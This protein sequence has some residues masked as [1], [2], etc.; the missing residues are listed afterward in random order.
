MYWERRKSIPE[1][2][3]VNTSLISTFLRLYTAEYHIER[4]AIYFKIT[5]AQAVSGK[6][7]EEEYESP[8]NNEGDNTHHDERDLS[9]LISVIQ[10]SIEDINRQP[11]RYGK[12]LNDLSIV[13]EGLQEQLTTSG[14][15]SANSLIKQKL[16]PR[17]MEHDVTNSLS[18]LD[19]AISESPSNFTSAV[20]AWRTPLS[21][22]WDDLDSAIEWHLRNVSLL[23]RQLGSSERIF[24]DISDSEGSKNKSLLCIREDLIAMALDSQ[25]E[26]LSD[27]TGLVL[28]YS[29]SKE[30]LSIV[31]QSHC[32]AYCGMLDRGY[33]GS[34]NSSH[35]PL[36]P[37]SF[38]MNF[39]WQ[40]ANE[41]FYPGSVNRLSTCGENIHP[42]LMI[43]RE[44]LQ[45]YILK[46]YAIPC[47]NEEDEQ[48]LDLVASDLCFIIF[49]E[50]QFS[51]NLKLPQRH[52]S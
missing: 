18:M 32:L 46:E 14:K 43:E 22:G 30:P 41:L 42:S 27:I 50:F 6:Y 13:I 17:K 29:E 34:Q 33:Q 15:F 31:L 21:S 20:E 44:S 24:I 9:Y 3:E 10:Q 28:S 1:D 8:A 49:D 7:T 11:N 19:L 48:T 16:P 45:A 26:I 25:S 47:F 37:M 2:L 36:F 35:S 4:T 40:N 5:F 39:V 23:I 12:L 52:G 51:E 38:W